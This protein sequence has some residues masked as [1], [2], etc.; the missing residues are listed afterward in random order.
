[1]DDLELVVLRLCAF[2]SR[3]PESQV[4][5]YVLPVLLRNQPRVS[6]LKRKHSASELQAFHTDS[7]ISAAG[8]LGSPK[9]KVRERSA[10][11]CYSKLLKTPRAFAP[12]AVVIYFCSERPDTINDTII[13]NMIMPH[14]MGSFSTKAGGSILG[15]DPRQNIMT[16]R[17]W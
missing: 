9:W 14:V 12:V 2:T 13:G 1:M 16:I 17:T 11:L 8:V 6:F 5:R 15:T 10:G 4:H 3:V 7:I